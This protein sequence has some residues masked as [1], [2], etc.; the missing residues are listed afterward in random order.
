M[1]LVRKLDMFKLTL[2]FLSINL[3]GASAESYWRKDG[4]QDGQSYHCNI[5]YCS[6]EMIKAR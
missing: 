3:F 1:N 4:A 2:I 6:M 5:L